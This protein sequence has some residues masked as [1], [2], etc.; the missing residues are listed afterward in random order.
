MMEAMVARSMSTA[1]ISFGLVTVP[2]RLYAASESQA[3]VSFNLLHEKCHSRLKQQYICPKDEEIVTRDQMVKGYEFAK[4]QYVV[5]TEDEIKSMAEEASK[6][7][8]ITE[9]VPLAK[10]DPIY[11]EGAYYLGPDKGGDKAYRLLSE[12]MRQTGRCALAKW[13]ARGK[14]YLV[15]MRPI[16][17][18]LI[19]Q[20]LHYADEV[21]PFSE[22]PVGDA[23]VKE[24]ELKLAV[25][26][27]EQIAT[28]EFRPQTYVDEVR[29]R[30]HEAI[31][32]KVEGQEVTA[33]ATPEA[34]KGQVID[35]MEALKA[36]LAQK[37]PRAV[38]AATSAPAT[39]ERKPAKRA[40]AARTAEA[41]TLRAPK[42]AA[43]GKRR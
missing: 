15:L 37:G 35:L 8:E 12:A 32:R 21:R 5:F 16:D 30:Y 14:Q 10:V 9:F 20:V 23:A 41:R 39:A 17:N 38:P 3:A 33:P 34:P 27:I 43:G 11:F 24:P 2:I 40:A 25:Q 42:A 6:T 26:L 7:I 31:Q 19:M 22:I 28:D 13:A 4:D 29:A 1:T 36:S 18:G